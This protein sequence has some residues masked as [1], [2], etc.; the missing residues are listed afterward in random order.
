MITLKEIK[1]LEGRTDFLYPKCDFNLY[2]GKVVLNHSHNELKKIIEYEKE[3]N[4]ED[5]IWQLAY[6]NFVDDYEKPFEL[7]PAQLAIFKCIFYRDYP[8]VHIVSSTQYG[9]TLNIANALLARISSHADE[10][11]VTVPDIK[12]GR[13]LL[14]Y[15]IKATSRNEYF[16][17]KL[18]GVKDKDYTAM[19]RLLEEK[20]KIK[21]T[22]QIIGK[23]D[24]VPR[25]G[26]VEL[27]TCEAHRTQDAIESIMGFGGNNV[28]SDESSLISD[29][30]EAGIFRMFAG[31][32]SDCCYIKIGNPFHRNHF[33]KSFINR[34]YKKIF[35]NKEIGLADGRYTEEFLE[36]AMEKP[37]AEILYNCEY[38]PEDAQDADGWSKLLLGED[39]KRAVLPEIKLISPIRLGVDCAGGGKNR[40]IIVAR[41]INGARVLWQSKTRDTMVIAEAVYDYSISLGVAPS[42]IMIDMIGLGRGVADRVSQLLGRP[43]GVNVGQA[44]TTKIHKK[45][46]YN[47]RALAYWRVRTWILKEGRLEKHPGWEQLSSSLFY[48]LNKG[49]VQIMSKEAMRKKGIVSPDEADALMLTFTKKDEYV[50]TGFSKKRKKE[51]S[52]FEKKMKLKRKKRQSFSSI[53]I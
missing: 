53:R 43:T 2:D 11:L 6:E 32:G 24:N 35:I 50:E 20:S 18:M 16:K 48:K 36:E 12:R 38:P 39:V 27:I 19:N 25:Y 10:W 5:P 26:S 7:T 41:G 8:R 31:K 33:Y 34:R 52:F 28:I 15:M 37:K 47:L 17:R 3:Q 1:Q 9:K 42:D 23:G 30:I 44:A 51:E 49:K 22:Y 14:K 45:E 40:S 21:L 29:E 46:F 13:N 4:K